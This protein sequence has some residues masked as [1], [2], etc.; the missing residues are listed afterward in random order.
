MLERKIY[1]RLLEWKA[2]E[3]KCLVIRGQRQVGKTFIVD[4]F[5]KTEYDHYICINFNDSPEFKRLFEGNI[6][7]HE[8]IRKLTLFFGANSIVE[9]ST[10]I[11]LDEIQECPAAYSALKQFTIYGK[12][13]VIASGSLLGTMSLM[14]GEDERLAPIGYEETIV[15]YPLD[16]EEFLWARGFQKEYIAEARRNIRER[17]PLEQTLFDRL[18]Q[19]FREFMI[20]GGMPEAVDAY[21][22][23]GDFRPANAVIG[24]ILS[25]CIRDINRYN[26]G[27]DRIKTMDCF[28]SIPHQ[29]SESNRKFMYSRIS[30]EGSRSAS[31]RYGGNLLW[32]REAGYGNF[33][34]S[35]T[36]PVHPLAGQVDRGSF[37]VYLSDTGMLLHMYGDKAKLAIYEGD[38]A[39]N[40]GAVAENVVAEGLMK[41][42]YPPMYYRKDKGAGRME[43]D[44]VEE[45]WDGIAV[46]EVKSGKNRIAPSLRKVAGLY[47]VA[48]RILFSSDNV[49]VDEEG[50]EHYPLFASAFINEIDSEP[51]GPR[52]S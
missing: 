20:V 13:D 22:K 48:R 37:K 50:I 9:G 38:T 35:V 5:A 2:R 49:H 43:L 25:T 3:H 34:Y 46:I 28:E 14:D 8:M 11:F 1:G 16:F 21:S 24:N 4:A 47:D 41:S 15:M 42:G 40:L 18:S 51:E 39:Y 17:T 52:F 6:S 33:C 31:D 7:A 23:S 10:L 30:G 29:L 12:L 27:T 32:I 36:Q 26:H 44:F 19:L 45:F